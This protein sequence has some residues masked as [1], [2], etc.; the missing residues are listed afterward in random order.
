VTGLTASLSGGTFANGAGL[1]EYTITGT[2]WSSGTANFSLS[3]G[4]QSCVLMVPVQA[5]S[6]FI[7][8]LN[9]GFFVLSG[10]LL[11][12]VSASGKMITVPYSGG[13]GGTYVGQVVNSSGVSGLTASV[14]GGTF[15]NGNGEL[16]YYL[17]GTPSGS[18]LASFSLNIGGQNCVVGVPVG[19]GAYVGAGVWKEFS[20]Y[21]L[22]SANMSADPYTPSWEI[23]GGY[24]QWGRKLEAAAGPIGTGPFESNSASIAG[25]NM[26]G[27]NNNAWLNNSKTV[28][29]PCPSGY[30]VPTLVQ[31]FGLVAN[32]SFTD[33]GT[34]NGSATNYSCGKLVGSALFLPAA[35]IRSSSNGDL[36]GRGYH[37]YYWSTTENGSASAANLYFYMGY[38][39]TG[40]ADRAYGQ[41]V[42]CIAE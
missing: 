28:N 25:W 26:S 19:C 42:R 16:V 20:C 10:G 23:N 22:G 29:D 4:G 24:W 31:W 8:S 32:N 27:A 40:N 18:G 7:L 11:P 5:A 38:E 33:V 15:M 1:L 9:C 34:W 17:N 13:N 30:R 3:L 12:G 2:P 36:N 41:S 39:G 14:A 35:G 21:N 6:G 37:G